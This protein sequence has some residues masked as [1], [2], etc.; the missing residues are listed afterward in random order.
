MASQRTSLPCLSLNL[1][2]KIFGGKK[3][4]KLGFENLSDFR[5]SIFYFQLQKVKKKRFPFG[6]YLEEIFGVPRAQSVKNDFIY[7]G[8]IY[9][10][11]C[12]ISCND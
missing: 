5:I 10:N 11:F 9:F 6:F 1:N 8:M 3:E 4:K 2:E 12:T 7:N